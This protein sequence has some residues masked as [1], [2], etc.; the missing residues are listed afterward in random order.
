MLPRRPTGMLSGV[1]KL[2]VELKKLLSLA[3]P[4]ALAQLAQNAM[5]FVDT[6]MVGRLGP[7]PLAGMALGATIFNV[8]YIV[9]MAILLSVAPIVAQAIGAR[10]KAEPGVVAGQALLLAAALA[11]PGVLLFLNVK[12]VLLFA[13]L[14]AGTAGLAAEYLGAVGLGLPFALGFVA[15]RG[16]FEGHGD[17][18]PILYMAILGVGFNVFLNN[19]LIYGHY[20]LPR[21]GMVGTGYSTA[22]VYFLLFAIAALLVRRRYPNLAVF[23]SMRLI[24]RAKMAEILRVGGPI[25]AMLGLESGLFTLTGVLM[26][27][28]GDDVLASHQL[29]LQSAS[30]A[31]MI[32]LGI[33]T[34]T[35][36][37]VGRSA[38]AGDLGGVRRSGWLGI[39]L[40]TL[41]M[42]CTALLFWLAPR[43]VIRLYIDLHAPQN[44]EL[45]SFAV[46]FLAIAALFQ[47]VDG[48]QVTA[49]GALRGLKDTRIP[50]FMTL[51]AY[52]LVGVPVGIYLSFGLRIGPRGLW[53]GMVAGLVVAAMLLV[54]RFRRLTGRP[55]PQPV[56]GAE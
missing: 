16:L 15:F 11:V 4:L 42:S 20:G 10:R 44:Q 52:W 28:F 40:G 29:A 48:V 33:A 50:M 5:S 38:G 35:S 26:A 24:D 3:L 2:T 46:T 12:P 18:R 34:A 21:L 25:S 56:L 43:S 36:V 6:L 37:R 14:P 55:R 51:V 31:F 17:A 22:I 47:V 30:M 13:G 39:G 19:A 27:G 9:L 53:F 45:I 8:V 41:F 1:S 54:A 49:Q 7:A 32:P 23:A